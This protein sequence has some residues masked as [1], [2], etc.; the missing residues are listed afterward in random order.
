VA[1]TETV[2]GR[3]IILTCQT[4]EELQAPVEAVE[5]TEERNG[6]RTTI[7]MR[8]LTV[9]LVLVISL[10]AARPASAI[11]VDL[12]TWLPAAGELFAGPISDDFIVADPDPP[13]MG[14]I[15]NNVYFDGTQ[16]TYVHTVNPSL[17]NNFVLNTAFDVAGYTGVAG[18]SFSE[19]AAAGGNGDGMDF[20]QFGQTQLGWA[21]LIG[22]PFNFGWDANE[23]ISFFF[24][25]TK[26]PT[27][28][29]YNLIGLESGTASSY[30]PVPEPGSIALLGSGL[31]GLYTAMRRRRNLTA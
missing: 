10:L 24:V 28:G 25:S 2:K 19:A 18:W 26:P 30:A 13:T 1:A 22:L 7:M 6:E 11:P 14:D 23:P 17:D 31:V 20:I 9:G 15:V 21:S 4:P 12:D 27:I 29:D 8:K 5:G 3:F 16:Y